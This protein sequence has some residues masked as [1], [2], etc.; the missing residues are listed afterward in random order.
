MRPAGLELPV[1]TAVPSLQRA[2][3]GHGAAVLAAPPG[4]GKTTLVPLA[5]S[6]LADG[7]PGPARRVLVAEPRRLAV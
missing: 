4:S 7:L 6:G 3:A 1:R 2:L 5:L